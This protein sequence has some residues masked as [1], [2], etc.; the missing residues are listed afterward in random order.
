MD[1]TIVRMYGVNSKGNSIV[2]H[3]YNFRPY[4]YM[5]CAFNQIIEQQHLPELKR[6]LN[7][8]KLLFIII[9]IEQITKP[10]RSDGY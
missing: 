8:I 7:V 5:Q 2:A 1:S 10:I 6:Y 3:I 9:F 4:F